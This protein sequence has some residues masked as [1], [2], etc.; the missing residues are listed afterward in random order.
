MKVAETLLF[1][2]IVTTQVFRDELQLPP[3][4][5]K[6]TPMFGVA[7]RVI[8]L[9][10]TK[11]KT[12]DALEQ[13][14]PFAVVTEPRPETFTVR[15]RVVSDAAIIGV[16]TVVGVVAMVVP[17]T[18]FVFIW[19]RVEARK[20]PEPWVRLFGVRMSLRYASWYRFTAA[21]VAGP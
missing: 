20:R 11:T 7:V 5:L 12:Q 10:F 19:F 16:F 14:Y 4:R 9:S 15:V 21:W 8:L 3:Q 1:R 18:P 17:V 6:E 2:D 13:V